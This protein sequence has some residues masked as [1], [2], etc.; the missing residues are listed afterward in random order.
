MKE[1]LKLSPKFCEFFASLKQ[2]MGL[3]DD[4]VIASSQK[5][6][7]DLEIVDCEDYDNG[8]SEDELTR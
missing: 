7:D 4:S 6:V 2:I 1:A 8:D 5:R 3:Y